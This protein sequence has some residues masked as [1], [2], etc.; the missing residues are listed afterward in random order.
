V[1]RAGRRLALVSAVAAACALG[2][3]RGARAEDSPKPAPPAAPASVAAEARLRADVEALA[4]PA[5]RGRKTPEDR[6]KAAQHVEAGLR[7]AGLVPLPGQTS[8][9]VPFQWTSP[10]GIADEPYV[11]ENVAGWLAGTGPDHVIVSAHYDHLGEK[12][13]AIHPGADDNA[14]GVAAL[15]ECARVLAKGPRPRR[16]IAFVAFDLEEGDGGTTAPVGS[17]AW[18]HRPPVPLERLSAFV[19]ADMLGRSLAD[20]YPGMLL[21]MGSERAKALDAIVRGLEV[22]KGHRIHRLGMDFNALGWS[23]YLPF[24]QARIPSLFFTS[25]ACVD[26]HRPGDTP[27]KIDYAALAVR[28]DLLA[29]TVRA[30]ADLP[31][32]SAD[33]AQGPPRWIEAPEPTLDEAKS[34]LEIVAQAEGKAKEMGI[35]E[36]QAMMLTAF[37][38]MV[39]GIVAGGTVSRGQRFLLRTGALRLFAAATELRPPK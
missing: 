17:S 36:G 3:P 7:A 22:P 1:T 39:E 34:V 2:R 29:K 24:E 5:L 6:A 16:S 21:V 23:D 33:E 28:T 31:A 35:P 15:L 27:D 25:G 18:V 19:T 10:Q 30:L 32:A 20:V 12:D 9:R 38:K 13:G 11:G 37:R 4:S 14:S 26:Y 8:F